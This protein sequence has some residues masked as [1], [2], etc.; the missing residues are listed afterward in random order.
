MH[1]I[2]LGH[3]GFSSVLNSIALGLKPWSFHSVHPQVMIA[4]W[5]LAFSGSGTMGKLFGFGFCIS[6]VGNL[7]HYGLLSQTELLLDLQFS[8]VGYKLA[9][10]SCKVDWLGLQASQ[11]LMVAWVWVYWVLVG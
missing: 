7:G 4:S 11:V 1:S 2:R 5:V 9:G 10:V 3:F 6:Q 8:F